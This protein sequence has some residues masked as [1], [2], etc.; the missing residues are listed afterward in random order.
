[1]ARRRYGSGSVTLARMDAGRDNCDF[2]TVRDDSSTGATGDKW[3]R[4]CKRSGGVLRLGSR[5][6]PTA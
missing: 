4:D 1:M 5:A 6:E 3:W 2:P